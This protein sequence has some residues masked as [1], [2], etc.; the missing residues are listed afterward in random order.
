MSAPAPRLLAQSPDDAPRGSRWRFEKLAGGGYCYRLVDEGVWIE[1]RYLARRFG[2]LY[3]E[4]DVCCNWSGV[5]RYGDSVVCANLE[6]SSLQA[7]RGFATHCAERTKAPK[8]AF[9]WQG[10]IDAVCLKTIQAE[11]EGEA[12]I[13]L[14]DAPQASTSPDLSI[15]PG[16]DIPTDATSLLIAHGDSL[17][18]LMLLYVLGTLAWRGQPVLLIDWEWT[19]ARHAARKRRLFGLERLD[20][21]HYVKAVAPLVT[22]ADRLRRYCDTH[23]ITFCALDSVGMACD[24]KLIDDDVALR[25]HRALATLPPSLC[26]AHV[27]K[28]SV[29]PEAKVEP[30]A[31][32]SV[33]FS[34]LARLC[35][36][37]KKE[38]ENEDTSVVGL[39]PTKQNDGVRRRPVGLRFRFEP[40]TITVEPADLSEVAGLSEKLPLIQRMQTLLKRGPQTYATI[41]EELGAKIDSVIKASKRSDAFLRVPG[42]NGVQRLALVERRQPE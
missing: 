22:E 29:G 12:G 20:N 18:S 36:S 21:L 16:F 8:S 28:S 5:P 27:P 42:D 31:F 35:W 13:R 1:L 7:R 41:A 15:V 11:R 3:G 25:F 17:K 24:G 34:N 9:D 30:T 2:G 14:D 40:A 19:A 4:L 32:G 39:F 33:Y 10:T 37:V 38:Q 23:G 6:L 26:A